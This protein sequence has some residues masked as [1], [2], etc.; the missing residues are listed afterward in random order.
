MS[1]DHSDLESMAQFAAADAD[2]Q[3]DERIRGHVQAG[4]RARMMR[5]SLRWTVFLCAAVFYATNYVWPDGGG[6][7][8]VLVLS[9][10]LVGVIC[11][12][13]L[14]CVGGLA[15]E[16]L[17]ATLTQQEKATIDNRLSRD[18]AAL[19]E[20]TGVA[21]VPHEDEDT[22]LSEGSSPANEFQFEGLPEPDANSAVSQHIESRKR[23]SRTAS[24]ALAAIVIYALVE[25]LT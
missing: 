8:T 15:P 12:G 20:E 17:T 13:I 1:D 4:R 22:P 6:I 5:I 9:S 24:G 18:Q 3:L 7:A 16:Q 25:L 11:I 19:A 21:A 2:R 14:F 23:Y 10:L